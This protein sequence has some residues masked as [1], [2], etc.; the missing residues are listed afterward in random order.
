MNYSEAQIEIISCKFSKSGIIIFSGFVEGLAYVITW[1]NSMAE[2]EK[3]FPNM[4]DLKTTAFELDDE[5]GLYNAVLDDWHGLHWLVKVNGYIHPSRVVRL[6][7]I[8]KDELY[9][10]YINTK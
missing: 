10:A 6:K 7:S 5:E 1:D 2:F 4:G 3:L 8:I 9:S